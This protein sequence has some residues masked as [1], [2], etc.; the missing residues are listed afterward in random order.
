MTSKIPL[1]WFILLPLVIL[2]AIYRPF[3]NAHESFKHWR[4]YR[5]IRPLPRT[6]KRALTL[7]LPESSRRGRKPQKTHNQSQSLF[8]HRL[9]YDI[10]RQIYEYVLAPPEFLH[11]VDTYS[12]RLG[13]IRCFSSCAEKTT[14]DAFMH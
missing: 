8:L 2:D 12:G 1:P 3:V 9:P 5:P 13:S 6:R 14:N 10:R 7:P 11:I 4:K